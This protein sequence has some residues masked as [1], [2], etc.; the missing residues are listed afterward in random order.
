M[1]SS[2]PAA[3]PAKTAPAKT[4]T[5]A[6]KPPSTPAK[7]PAARRRGAD[8][9]H[10]RLVFRTTPA[11]VR[12]E[13]N[14]KSQGKTP[15]TVQNLPFGILMVRLEYPGYQPLQRRV[16]LNATRPAETL[17]PRTCAHAVAPPAPP[18]HRNRRA[19]PVEAGFHGGVVFES[20]PAG[21]KVFIDNAQVGVT[22]LSMPSVRAGSHA[23]RFELNGFRRWTASVRVVAGELYAGCR[24]ARG[25]HESMNAVLALEDGTWFRGTAAGAEGEAHGE[26]VFNTSMTGYQEVLTD[27]SYAGQI[28]TMTYPQIG[29]YGVSAEDTESGA[30]QVAGFVVR[31]N[32][33]VASN[34]RADRTLRDYLVH[35][36]HRRDRRH[37]HPVAHAAAA[38]GR[39][40]CAACSRPAISIPTI[41]SN[42]PARFPTW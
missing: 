17:I 9:Q 12:V 28:V 11:G 34:L 6:A 22:P 39:R 5:P 31:E 8:A 38:V 19:R 27:P 14:G 2:A 4:P 36:Q 21:A 42:A 7:P 1:T 24:V 37:R 20:R 30:A 26:V 25:G 18:R 16:V 29:N 35:N 13:I 32:S 3:A 10:G 33:P 41:S 40:A 23:V 15:L